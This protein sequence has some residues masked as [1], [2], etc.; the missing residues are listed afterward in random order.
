MKTIPKKC[1]LYWDRS[2]MAWLNLLTV[3]SFHKYN[4]DW[5]II[6]YLT[7]QSPRELGKNTFVPDYT[8][9]DYFKDLLALDYV[10]F[11]EIDVRDYGVPLCAHSCQGSDNF[12]REILYREGGVYSDFDMLWLKPVEVLRD[13]DCIGNPEDFECIVSF[14]ALTSGFHNVSNL[15]AEPGSPFLKSLIEISQR[16]PDEVI[17]ANHQALGSSMLNAA[18]PTLDSILPKF[19]R[20]LAIPYETFYPYSTYYMNTLFLDHTL[21]QIENKNVLGVHWFN[22]NSYAKEY[23]NRNDYTLPCSMTT[24]LKREGYI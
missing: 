9:P 4:P 15:I 23:I 3:V 17:V 24:I 11:K 6:V 19:P 7:K 5:E 21:V 20:I 18:Y 16:I 22:G 8:G 13:V 1:H 12:R 14:F 10:T 2:P